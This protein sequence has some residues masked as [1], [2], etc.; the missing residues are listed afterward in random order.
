MNNTDTAEIL[1]AGRRIGDAKQFDGNCHY[2]IIKGDDYITSLEHLRATPFRKRGTIK[3]LTCE[4]FIEVVNEQKV[5]ETRIFADVNRD[6][7]SLSAVIN[8]HQSAIGE[9]GWN[10]YIIYYGLPFSEEWLL[11]MLNSQSELARLRFADLIEENMEDIISPDA[12]ELVDL[13]RTVRGTQKMEVANVTDEQSGDFTLNMKRDTE[14]HTK[15]EKVT[16][17][18][19]IVLGIPVFKG[20]ARVKV[21][22][23]L[24]YRLDTEKGGFYFNTKI[25]RPHVSLEGQ[26]NAILERIAKETKIRPWKG[27]VTNPSKL[28]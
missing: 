15:T 19:E 9:P 14:T 5:S 23:K 3:M 27:E 22:A 16:I 11:W 12:A 18:S 13:V 25:M 10:D 1:N 21:T 2:A 7:G 24:R 8:F 6:G 26:L 17:P 20:E 4:D 28:S